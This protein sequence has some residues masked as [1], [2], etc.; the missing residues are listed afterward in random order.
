MLSSRLPRLVIRKSLKNITAQIIQY[1]PTGDKVLI[2]ATTKELQKTFHVPAQR[3]TTTAYLTGYLIGQ[4]AKRQKI[5]KAIADIGLQSVTKGSILFSCIK[6][7]VDAGLDVP[8][9]PD[10]FPADERV[11]GK[12]LK[13]PIDT[14]KI[15]EQ[16]RGTQ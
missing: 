5:D 3:N 9:S 13:N 10:V 12:H 16:L 14:K 2:T 8:H 1:M 7:A 11:H 15:I 4:K 6:G